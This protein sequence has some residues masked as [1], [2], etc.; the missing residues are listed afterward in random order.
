MTDNPPSR[1]QRRL[2]VSTFLCRAILEWILQGFISGSE[3]WLILASSRILFFMSQ[4]PP[5][6]W[7]HFSL[8]CNSAMGFECH[9]P[10]QKWGRSPGGLHLCIS[11]KLLGGRQQSWSVD[12]VHAENG[13]VPFKP[14]ELKHCQDTINLKGISH[15]GEKVWTLGLSGWNLWICFH[16]PIP[17]YWVIMSTHWVLLA[18]AVFQCRAWRNIMQHFAL[19]DWKDESC[20][21]AMCFAIN[22]Y[23]GKPQLNR[24]AGRVL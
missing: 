15:G 20:Q 8:F 13:G 4:A 11:A 24:A 2:R 14:V 23:V 7:M 16:F 17:A 18:I 1:T 9:A 6:H 19:I 3:M 21:P 22:P 12:D 5:H 10:Y